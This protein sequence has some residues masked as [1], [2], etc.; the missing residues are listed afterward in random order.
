MIA[1]LQ[2][3]TDGALAGRG[4]M[5]L[6]AGEPGI[7]K[8]ALVARAAVDAAAAGMVVAWGRGAE[9]PG[10]P[11][12]WPWTQVLRNLGALTDD[13]HV[14]ARHHADA[15][16]TSVDDRF[17]M[18]ERVVSRLHD[19]SRDRGLL[20]VLD[21]L[22]WADTDS[23]RL[24]EFAARHLEERRVLLLGTYRDTEASDQLR[25][26]AGIAE[27]LHLD[28]LAVADV[29][30]VMAAMMNG[31]VADEEAARMWART[32][33]NPLFVRE[34]T[35]LAQARP[36]AADP[37]GVAAIV[38][39]VREV[40]D[41]RLARLSQP[42]ARLLG[43]AALD[44]S[45]VRGWLLGRVLADDADVA[46]LVDEAVAT[47][48]LA[49]DE[50]SHLRFAHDLF[51]EVL[52]AAFAAPARRR[53]H[54]ALGT[55]LE[56]AR[57]EGVVVHPAELAAHFTGAAAAGDATA[58]EP[59]VRYGREAA[60]DA[61][62]RLAFDDAAANLARALEALD[63]TSP[64]PGARLALVL[65]LAAA[66][67]VAGQ[68]AAAS[69]A[70]RDAYSIARH[71][72]DTHSQA[73]AAI[74]LHHVGVKTGP[75]PERDAQADLLQATANALSADPGSSAARVHA[76][77]ARTL[78]HSMEASRMAR[79]RPVAERAVDLAR[80]SGDPDAI[81]D[82][83]LAL[84]D[85]NWSPGTA[86]RRLDVLGELDG[87]TP[88]LLAGAV[89]H[90]VMLLRAEALLELGDP[91]CRTYIEDV[92]ATAERTRAPVSQW[93]AVSRRAATALLS[94]RIEEAADLTQRAERIAE[95]T[96]DADA[97]WIADIQ[98]WELARFTG[99]RSTYARKRPDADPTVEAWPPWRA[100]ILLDADELD[101]ATASLAGF[102]AGQ[103][104]GPGVNAGYDLWFPAIAAEA[105]ARCGT[106]QLRGDLYEML[107]PFA[108]THVG[109]GAWVAYCGPVDHYLGAL[110]GS[111]GR[112]DAASA[113][114]DAA[115]EQCRQLHA[116]L[117]ADL[118]RDR[119]RQ[120]AG[121]RGP[122]AKRFK[123][124][125]PVWS[126]AFDGTQA[127][128]PDAKGIRDI[129]TLLARPGQPVP[130]AQLAGV[131][132][133]SSGQPALDRTALAAYRARLQ[134]LAD[135]I[136][137]ADAEH[138]SER[139][140]RARV[141]RDAIVAELTRSVGR[142]GRPRRLGDDIERARKTV[143]A[144]IRRALRLIEQHHLP[145]AN[146]LRDSLET[147]TTC[148]YKPHSPIDWDLAP[149]SALRPSDERDS[150]R[151]GAGKSGPRP[152][153]S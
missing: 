33:G 19:A 124:I 77:L 83:L 144:R 136:A 96:G 31:V 70:Y 16:G 142:G 12:Y 8:T 9:G 43:L 26:A 54:R 120:I 112:V 80:R 145:L 48:V 39:S 94:G 126:V 13:Q 143:S 34:L 23:L 18:F 121:P 88:A 106:D 104:W 103:A 85:V 10:S 99:G 60:A 111:L 90:H 79:A 35:R 71:L 6:V 134:D 25:H 64:E 3:A 41:R 11:A 38:D 141:E 49:I 22:H 73:R 32:G 2:A 130:A 78:H 93:L 61:A 105:A 98:R 72:G 122:S 24:L 116:P 92:C 37:W 50:D 55:A 100:V 36:T 44:G 146:H 132:F 62:S 74:G 29:A 127:L 152:R 1:A 28:G 46:S 17:T 5:V 102:T 135:D 69:A 138:D 67:R 97:L 57:R 14:G 139:A 123:R 149:A 114:F 153:S 115:A 119:Y 95:R 21:D 51:R 86:A 4:A 137:H 40:I 131:A 53:A 42:C 76:A 87:G 129:A 110:A 27:V 47:R 20:V 107:A 45:V 30:A 89:H 150:E 91:E 147:G 113:H 52:V 148:T 125:G 58:V 82:A 108:G 133:S 84:H 101:T 151:G 75:S 81:V 56:S 118:G 59:A 63:T 65:D 68:L 140:A 66:R 117:W 7:G 109:C 128:I 15:P